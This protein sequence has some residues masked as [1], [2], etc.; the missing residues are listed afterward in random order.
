MGSNMITPNLSVN[1]LRKI[2][3]S[4]PLTLPRTTSNI[5]AT[6]PLEPTVLIHPPQSSNPKDTIQIRLLS[7]EMRDGMQNLEDLKGVESPAL[8]NNLLSFQS[9]ANSFSKLAPNVPKS[10]TLL[11]HVHGGGFIAHSS[12]SHEIY[13]KPWAKEL[14]VPIVSIDYSLAPEHMFPRASEECF[15]VYAWCLLNADAL[16]W[17]GEK[18]ICVGDSAGGVLVNIH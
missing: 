8:F 14:R 12:K 10:P 18:I 11:L 13:L 9:S 4:T 3:L 6:S 2:S 1:I 15:Y 5:D 7:H 17:T 16:G